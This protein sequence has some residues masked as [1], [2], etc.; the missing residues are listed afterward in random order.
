MG[1]KS[2]TPPTVKSWIQHIGNTL[3]LERYIYQHRGGLVNLT[4]YGP[5]GLIHWHWVPKNL[6]KWDCSNAFRSHGNHGW[7]LL[8]DGWQCRI[9][10][11]L[12][13]GTVLFYCCLLFSVSLVRWVS[14]RPIMA[15]WH[16][17]KQELIIV[18]FNGSCTPLTFHDTIGVVA[19]LNILNHHC[20]S[21]KQI[22]KFPG[23][24]LLGSVQWVNMCQL[25]TNRSA[26]S[27]EALSNVLEV[28]KQGLH[29]FALYW[30]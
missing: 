5:H 17:L 10:V 27:T 22:A 24:R 2:D 7:W 6:F 13:P 21:G 30:A 15:G 19:I 9:T 28:C 18:H 12:L 1:W 20:R 25:G 8:E 16:F 26:P 23:R 29:T 11:R 4:N 14:C 3:I